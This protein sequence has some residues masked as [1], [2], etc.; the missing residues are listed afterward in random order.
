MYVS[1][2]GYSSSSTTG[3]TAGIYLGFS[4]TDLLS[5]NASIR[6]HG[7]QLRCLSE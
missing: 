6:A 3:D 7:I 4:T 1:N 5:S 2:N